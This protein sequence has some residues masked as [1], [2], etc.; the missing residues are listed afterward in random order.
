MTFWVIKV[1]STTIGE[2]FAD[3]LAVNVGLGP[4][5]TDAVMIAALVVA[6]VIQF[7]TRAYT[8]WI[9]WLC[10]VLVSIVGTQLT[11]FFTDTLGVSLYLST[12]VFALILAVVFAVWYRQERTL[13]ITSIDTPRREAFYWGA[14][15][16]T[17][18]LGTAAGDLATEALS[19]GF[20]NG[21]LIFGGLILATW[22]AY[23]L[24]AGQVL[25]FW[26]AYVLTRPLGASLGDLL[27]QDKD[28][29]GLGLGASVTSLLFFGTIVVLAIREQVLVSRHGVA[30][31][32]AGPLGGHR[33]DYM[34]AAAA[35]A[36]VALVGWAL[37]PAG[38]TTPTAE[39]APMT[40][41]QAGNQAGAPPGAPA[42]L[43]PQAHPTTKLGNL[44]K[45]AVIVTDVKQKVA[46]N[47]LAGGKARVKDLEVAWDDAEAGLKPRDSA[48]WHQLDDQIDAV[49]TA[50]RASNPVQGDCASAVDTLMATLNQFDGVR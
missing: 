8:P 32:G 19:L 28:F 41:A 44:D 42:A 5:V 31:K 13:A 12:A 43:P 34:W 11:D 22:V 33:Q 30:V 25:T 20:R 40:T 16:T 7:R 27:T 15:L 18:A 50:L 1:L 3:Y 4:A 21:V 38:D 37:R 9:Y 45:F 46:K 35:V 36:A 2:T 49:L 48:K 26:I 24:G 14:I 17:F 29:G 10:V 23:R 39:P 6:L 47:D